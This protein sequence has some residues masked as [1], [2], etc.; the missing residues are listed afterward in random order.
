MHR[1]ILRRFHG[2]HIKYRTWPRDGNLKP[3]FQTACIWAHK[4]LSPSAYYLACMIM[5]QY[6]S[7]REPIM[8]V[9][10]PIMAVTEPIMAVTEPIMAVKEPIMAVTESPLWWS[11]RAHYGGHREPIMAVTESP[12]WRSKSPLWRS[13][14]AHYGGH[15]EPIMAV[16]ESPWWWSQWVRY[17][18]H[19]MPRCRQA[20]DMRA[21]LFYTQADGAI[22]NFKKL[23]NRPH[24]CFHISQY[25]YRWRNYLCKICLA[26]YYCKEN[27]L[28]DRWQLT[29]GYFRYDHTV[30]ESPPSE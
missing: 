23:K 27:H 28:I 2:I 19:S 16:T 29:R 25:Q 7:H 4:S 26:T 30:W 20:L 22:F 1:R 3:S 5:I 8:A 18:G 9:T 17:G 14:R 6:C 12:L 13:Q 10:E 15:R 11:Q 21:S 24:V